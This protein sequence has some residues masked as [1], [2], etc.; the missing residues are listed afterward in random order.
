MRSMAISTVLFFGCIL[1]VSHRRQLHRFLPRWSFRFGYLFV[2]DILE[3]LRKCS[4]SP[5]CGLCGLRS[6]KG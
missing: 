2:K 5:N 1:P 4:L 3:S 6:R